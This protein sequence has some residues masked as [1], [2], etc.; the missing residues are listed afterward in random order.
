MGNENRGVNCSPA[1][2]R[3]RESL[4]F[5]S[6]PGETM[7]IPPLSWLL[8]LGKQR[9]RCRVDWDGLDKANR[10]PGQLNVLPQIYSMLVA[11][12]FIR[13]F[14][15]GWGVR[16]DLWFTTEVWCEVGK[17]PDTGI[18]LT[19]KD[20]KERKGH[21]REDKEGRGSVYTL[22]WVNTQFW[23]AASDTYQEVPVKLSAHHFKLLR[24]FSPYLFRQLKSD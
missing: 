24:R 17:R 5:C 11:L 14:R 4:I 13:W 12:I 22:V 15:G 1:G 6:Y 10:W 19:A 18:L 21:V 23:L 16:W 2:P 3:I 7:H 9:L 20:E 8:W